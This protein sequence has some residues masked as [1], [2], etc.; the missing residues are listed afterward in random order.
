MKKL[1][2]LATGFLALGSISLVLTPS[3]RIGSKAAVPTKAPL[4]HQGAQEPREAN[5]TPSAASLTIGEIESLKQVF[6]RWEGSGD[7]VLKCQEKFARR[8]RDDP[9]FIAE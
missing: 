9:S 7:Q 3:V 2:I 8:L 5:S 1:L 4:S 6:Q